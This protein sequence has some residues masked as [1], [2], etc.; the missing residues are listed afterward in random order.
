M[1]LAA[2]DVGAVGA[3]E[4]GDQVAGWDHLVESMGFEAD[5]EYPA[6]LSGVGLTDEQVDLPAPVDLVDPPNVRVIPRTQKKGASPPEYCLRDK[7]GNLEAGCAGEQGGHRPILVDFDFPRAC[8]TLAIFSRRR[9]KSEEPPD[10][11]Q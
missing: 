4:S 10:E 3:Y 1:T 6:R 9:P 5:A 11:S 7:Q 2:C 8:L